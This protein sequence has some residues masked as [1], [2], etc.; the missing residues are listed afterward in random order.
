MKAHIVA[1]QCT[2]LL[3][4]Y[5]IAEIPLNFIR[6][7]KITLSRFWQREVENRLIVFKL[8]FSSKIKGLVHIL[9]RHISRRPITQHVELQKHKE[10]EGMGTMSE[11]KNNSM[12][13]PRPDNYNN[14]VPWIVDVSLAHWECSNSS[15]ITSV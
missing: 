15:V 12:L 14:K 10:F 1:I 3:H 8:M 11:Q 4:P 5:F 2:M 6:L 13:S 7:V 9:L